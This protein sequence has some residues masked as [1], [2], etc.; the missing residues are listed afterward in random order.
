MILLDYLA[1]MDAD[2]KSVL[3]L[4]EPDFAFCIV[5]PG[6]RS[7]GSSRADFAAYLGGR[8]AVTRE[9][10]VLR[11]ARD[12]DFET[13]QGFVLD[14]GRPSGAFLSAVTVSPAGLMARYQST[15]TTDFALVDLDAA[16]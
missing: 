13:A 10:R 4:L 5:L 3:A 16:A 11:H 7:R 15:F 8:S 12:G 14:D 2:P 9:H 6:G 1:R